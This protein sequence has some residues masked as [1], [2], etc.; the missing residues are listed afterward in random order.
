MKKIALLTWI[1]YENYGTFLQWYAICSVL[2][3]LGYAVDS[4]QYFPRETA[5]SQ[6]VPNK[7]TSFLTYCAKYCFQ[8][9]FHTNV[10]PLSY[11]QQRERHAQFECFR[12]KHFSLTKPC[13]TSSQ[14]FTLNDDY[15]YFV[16]GSDQIWS[17]LCFDSHYFLDFVWDDK[18]KIAYAP[19]IGT[20]DINNPFIR[21]KIASLIRRFEYVSIRENAGKRIINELTGQDASVVLD[22]TLLIDSTEWDTVEDKAYRVPPK[23]ILCY[24]L[25]HNEKYWEDVQQLSKQEKLPLVIIPVFKKDFSRSQNVPNNVGPAQFLSLVKNASFVCTDS[26]HG[27]IFSLLYKKPF[28]VFSRF[29]TKD[30]R[31]QNSRIDTFCENFNLNNRRIS[32]RNSLKEV[33]SNQIDWNKINIT[34]TELRLKSINYL[35]SAFGINSPLEFKITNTCCGCGACAAICP[36][37]AITIRRDDNGFLQSFV[38]N[39]KCVQCKR[40]RSVCPFYANGSTDITSQNL[41][42]AAK[43][44]NSAVLNESSSGGIGFELMN[45]FKSDGKSVTGCIY[46]HQALSAIGKSVSTQDIENTNLSDFQGSKYIQSD[47][48]KVFKDLKRLDGGIIIG[49]PCQ[50]AAAHNYLKQIGRRNEFF[51]ADI[52]C[53]GVPSQ[54]LWEKYIIESKKIFHFTENPNVKF[55]NKSLGWA[56]RFISLALHE[57]KINLSSQKDLFYAFFLTGNC[58]AESCYECNF[59]CASSADIRIA[60]YWDPKYYKIHKNGMSMCIPLTES[61]KSILYKLKNQ[62]KIDCDLTDIQDMFKFQQTK[63]TFVPLEREHVLSA[64]KSNIPLKKIKKQY[65][66]IYSLQTKI[67]SALSKIN[68]IRMLL[69]GDSL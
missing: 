55:R 59:R 18:K 66:G 13:Y 9:I 41:L 37:S 35:Q 45:Y 50:I 61:G 65:L 63:N 19:S 60:D 15:D 12:N 42:Y 27:S 2:K 6:I 29:K 1:T 62:G 52:I 40:C 58:Y 48:S 14:L 46:D 57:K 56:R 4:I 34:L 25:G 16:C 67:W 26:Y 17:P 54:N 23:Y 10:R 39:T 8:E 22:P 31:N 5:N 51:L 43:S 53:H 64:F 69:R 28:A 33:F 21:E 30:I 47:Y 7:K 44:K 11:E 36:K 49:L 20:D 38:D 3:N 68:G 32:K 24:F